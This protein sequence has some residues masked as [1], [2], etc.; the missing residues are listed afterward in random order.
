MDV[1]D[2]I[3]K[4]YSVRSYQDKEVEEEKLASI[5]EAA[6][7]AP[8]ASNRQEWRFVAV[9]DKNR[10]Q[11]LSEAAS[12]Q[13]FVREAPVVIACCAETDGH[14]M[15]CGHPCFLIDAAIAIDHIT[16]RAAELGLGSCWIGSFDQEEVKNILDIPNEIT[17]VELLTV[18]YAADSPKEKRRLDLEDIVKYEK[19]T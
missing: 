4:R 5:F 11:Q 13:Q 17:V 6:R 12:G 9:R 10:R 2:A 19:W 1:I 15:A 3:K 16:L 7:L 8:S 14:V 18:G